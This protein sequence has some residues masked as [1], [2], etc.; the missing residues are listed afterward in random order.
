[1]GP[2]AG[3]DHKNDQRRYENRLKE[4]GLFSLEKKKLQGDPTSRVS[5]T[6]GGLQENW[7]GVVGIGTGVRALV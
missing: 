5:V 2:I 6:V 1:M 3:E 7:R 4:L